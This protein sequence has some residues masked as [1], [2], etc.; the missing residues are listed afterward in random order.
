MT[1]LTQKPPLISV[2]MSVYNNDRFLKIAIDS[3]LSQT[4]RDFE[5][6]IVDDGSTDRS[7]QILQSCAAKDDRIRIIRQ[8]N[9]GVTR[10]LNTLI[11]KAKG[12]FLARMDADDISCPTRF[13]QQVQFLQQHPEV[14]CVGGC[15]DFIDEAGRVLMHHQTATTDAEIQQLALT[16]N[17]PI[18]HPSAMM[19]RSAVVLVGG[20]DPSFKS[21][22]DLDLWLKLGE[23]GKLANL[24]ET[25]LLYRQH[26]Q[27]ASEQK[28]LEQT[29]N[30]R[31]ACERAWKRRR[32]EGQFTATEAWRPFDRTSRHQFMLRYGWHFFNQGERYA[33]IVYGVRSIQALPLAIDGWKLLACALIKPVPQPTLN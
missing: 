22:Q 2:I 9:Q 24:P 26:A 3:I 19:R 12:E 7:P 20:Y 5:F 13:A 21:A 30:R 10:S 6:L 17:T 1:N 8:A 11:Q 31:L 18:N 4:F 25:V 16:G 27:S 32:I 15:Y 28:Q 29:A 23:V 14:V 33:A